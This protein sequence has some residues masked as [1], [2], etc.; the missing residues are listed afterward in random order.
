M[1][2]FKIIRITHLYMYKKTINVEFSKLFMLF[3]AYLVRINLALKNIVCINYE[4]KSF[5]VLQ[6]YLQNYCISIDFIKL[7]ISWQN[8]F[9]FL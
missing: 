5:M 1:L 2:Y 8:T 6:S 7:Y 9:I 4:N 3:N